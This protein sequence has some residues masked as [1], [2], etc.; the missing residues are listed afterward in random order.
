MATGIPNLTNA[1][2]NLAS[3]RDRTRKE[4]I[5]ILDSVRGRKA[6]ILDPQISGPLGL[7]AESSLLKVFCSHA[8]ANA[9]NTQPHT[10]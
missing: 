8:N 7:I 1:S 4:L 3:L 9:A 10:H 6:L 5:D 2:V